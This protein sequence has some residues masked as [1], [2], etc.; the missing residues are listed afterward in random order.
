MAIPANPR[1]GSSVLQ[2]DTLYASSDAEM[3]AEFAEAEA[4][5]AGMREQRR[6]RKRARTSGLASASSGINYGRPV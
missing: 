6:G 3:R 1:V 5:L 2:R 4:E